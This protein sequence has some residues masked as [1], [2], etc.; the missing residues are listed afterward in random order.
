MIADLFPGWSFG[1]IASLFDYAFTALNLFAF[2][3]VVGLAEP[4]TAVVCP[5]TPP[6]E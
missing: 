5:L 2:V 3:F 6:T 1:E 4:S